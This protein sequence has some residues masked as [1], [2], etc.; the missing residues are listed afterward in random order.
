M[1]KK[2]IPLENQKLNLTKF[3]LIF[4]K[5]YIMRKILSIYILSLIT[6]FSCNNTTDTNEEFN[7][8]AEKFQDIQ[9]LRYQIPG[10][11]ELN[12]NQKKLVYYLTEAGLAGGDIMYDQNYRHNLS[13][14]RA[15]EKIYTNYDGDKRADEWNNFE[16]YLKRIWFANGIHHH[17]SNDKFDPNFSK[18]YLEYLL[19]ETGTQLNKN[20]FEVIFNENDSKKVNRD[21]N[22]GIIIGS[23]VNFYDPDITEEEVESFYNKIKVPNPN[24]PISLGLNS[25]LIREDGVLKEKVWKKGGMYSESIEKIIENLEIAKK[26]AENKKQADALGLLIKYYETGDLKIWDDYNVFMKFL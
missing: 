12:L 8:F 6:I 4:P 10:F 7:L 26:Y 18:E 17:Y 20:A 25:K 2:N 15:L 16:V 13:I 23:S 11:D 14:R 1:T 5:I 9:V 3:L 19:S 21:K 24:K 22:K